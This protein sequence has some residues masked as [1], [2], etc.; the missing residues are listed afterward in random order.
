[1]LRASWH[2]ARLGGGGTIPDRALRLVSSWGSGLW[3]GAICVSSLVA[4]AATDD[5]AQF[6]VC[7]AVCVCVCSFSISWHVGEGIRQGIFGRGQQAG[8]SLQFY[9][10]STGIHFLKYAPCGISFLPLFCVMQ[11]NIQL[12]NAEK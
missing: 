6:A 10:A 3:V 11:A 4:C 9:F 12:G 7:R 8:F 5:G 2:A 1:M